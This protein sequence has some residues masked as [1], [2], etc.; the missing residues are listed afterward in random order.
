LQ[1]E[2]DSPALIGG[3]IGGVGG[4]LCITG[5][6]LFFACRRKQKSAHPTLT[7]TRPH[8]SVYASAIFSS[9]SQAYDVGNVVPESQAEYASARAFDGTVYASGFGD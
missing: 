7:E 4:A 5:A 8:S 2:D 3:I 6:A 1:E 9:Q